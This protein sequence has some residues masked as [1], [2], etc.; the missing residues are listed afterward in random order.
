MGVDELK[1]I[2]DIE[3]EKYKK[4][5]IDCSAQQ[6]IVDSQQSELLERLERA[7]LNKMKDVYYIIERDYSKAIFEYLSAYKPTLIVRKTQE[8]VE[9]ESVFPFSFNEITVDQIKSLIAL[10][11]EDGGRYRIKDKE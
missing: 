3:K 10:I 6:E 2:L 7:K 5:Q 8:V 4:A 11:E 9:W 1:S